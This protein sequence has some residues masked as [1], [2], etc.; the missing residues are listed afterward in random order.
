MVRGNLP[1]G[2]KK[3]SVIH[4][5]L[6]LT[7]INRT[8]AQA[9]CEGFTILTHDPEFSAFKS[10]GEAPRIKR[11]RSSGIDAILEVRRIVLRLRSISEADSVAMGMQTLT[12]SWPL[13]PLISLRSAGSLSPPS[14]TKPLSGLKMRISRTFRT[15]ATS[16]KSKLD[17]VGLRCRNRQGKFALF[18]G[19]TASCMRQ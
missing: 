17:S 15:S 4:R 1:E 19:L 5:L 10:R 13:K 2:P 12:R 16:R 11:A 18:S 14:A 3:S 6:R 8:H 9:Q 7:Q